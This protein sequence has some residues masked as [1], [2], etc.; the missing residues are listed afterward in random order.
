VVRA[1]DDDVAFIE[2]QGGTLIA[3]W[4]GQVSVFH[5]LSDLTPAASQ[6]VE[7]LGRDL[8]TAMSRSRIA[9]TVHATYDTDGPDAAPARLQVDYSIDGQAATQTIDNR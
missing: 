8:T 4:P 6:A 7:V 3:S 2:G 1:A 5:L 9:V